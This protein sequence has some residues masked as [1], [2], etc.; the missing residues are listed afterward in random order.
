MRV[1]AL[2]LEALSPPSKPDR[3]SD[4]KIWSDRIWIGWDWFYTL[5][6][7]AITHI[8]ILEFD[9]IFIKYGIFSFMCDLL[10]IY[11]LN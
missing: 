9:E 11:D 6:L 2:K 8:H 4:I 1:I 3:L 5:G 10:L 7:T